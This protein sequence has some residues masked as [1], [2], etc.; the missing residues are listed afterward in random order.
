MSA[1]ICESDN[2]QIHCY[3]GSTIYN[4]KTFYVSLQSTRRLLTL[5]CYDSCAQRLNDQVIIRVS[6]ERQEQNV[7]SGYRSEADEN[8]AF[9][10]YCAAN[11]GNF[12]P[13]FRDKHS[14]SSSRVRDSCPFLDP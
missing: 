9:L 3:P 10:S 4:N 7:I 5:C 13:T 8:C 2:M 12:L 11:G 14:V 6:F 1:E